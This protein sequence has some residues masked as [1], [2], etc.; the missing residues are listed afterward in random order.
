MPL[1]PSRP[2]R[3]RNNA[4]PALPA[5]IDS[6]EWILT[7]V[8]ILW[9]AVLPWAYGTM[10]ET[11][12]LVS[13]GLASLAL[14]IALLP[15]R[16]E[17][18]PGM[19]GPVQTRPWHLFVRL[20]LVWIGLML[21]VYVT[22]QGL[23]PAWA[24]Q[25][26]STEWWLEKRKAITWLPSGVDAPFARM[27]AWRT[28][29]IWTSPFL[30]ASALWIGITRRRTLQ[31]LALVFVLNAV[32]VT[33]LG[34][35]QR[36]T[37]LNTQ[38]G[39]FALGP[40]NFASFLYRNHAAAYFIIAFAAAVG[41]AARHYFRGQETNAHSTPAPV[42]AFLAMILAT[43]IFLSLSRLGIVFGALCGL[44]LAVWFGGK[45]WRQK[46]TASPWLIVL[47]LVVLGGFGTAFFS[48]V[49]Y[50]PIVSRFESLQSSEGEGS[51][52]VRS[53]GGEMAREMFVDAPLWGV[54]A[55][56]YRHIEPHYS[57]AFPN[58]TQDFLFHTSAYW[59]RHYVMQDAHN[60]H[61]QVLAE[62]GVV[63][64]LL[65]YAL[66]AWA[67]A[68]L[69]LRTRRQHPLGLTT[70]VSTLALLLF[71]TLDFLFLNPA[72]LGTLALL[73]ALSCRWADLEG[74]TN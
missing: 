68:A 27:N 39:P 59:F 49:D 58:L 1:Y 46:Q 4:A 30:A 18:V 21:F 32:G 2:N 40:R 14:L 57:A 28:L 34:M 22:V 23:N 45:L 72:I 62:L 10:R 9:L 35:A 17:R 44:C 15:R 65:V 54:G 47:T 31:T 48:L 56:G 64:G 16:L 67:L 63:G 33:L 71:A 41:L 55:G 26:S 6:R 69:S 8:L 12:Q 60:D 51:L 37:D 7:F 42:F 36:M 13:L 5:E 24:Y 53:L 50:K 61:L 29:V 25:Q 52:L 66:L 19:A 20:P 3:T 43:G 38:L 73:I 74:R 11:G 70:L